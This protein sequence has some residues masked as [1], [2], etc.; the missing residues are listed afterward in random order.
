MI[1]INENDKAVGKLNFLKLGAII[2]NSESVKA[3]DYR[4]RVDNWTMGMSSNVS[5]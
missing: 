2:V 1:G 5:E 4:T 3:L